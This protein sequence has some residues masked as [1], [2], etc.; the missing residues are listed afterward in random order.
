[1][2]VSALTKKTVKRNKNKPEKSVFEMVTIYKYTYVRPCGHTHTSA[3]YWTDST[4]AESHEA[5]SKANTLCGTCLHNALT[6]EQRRILA[7]A[8]HGEDQPEEEAPLP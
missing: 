1:M 3:T 2:I 8:R 7:T 4:V 5:W 6:P